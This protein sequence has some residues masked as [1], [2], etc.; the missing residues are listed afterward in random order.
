MNI[1]NPTAAEH[2][3]FPLELIA[4]SVAH[5]LRNPLAGIRAAAQLAREGAL[6]PGIQEALRDVISEVD[7][8]DSR[9]RTFLDFSRP[10]C[11]NVRPIQ[12]EEWL[13]GARP[14]IEMRVR[15]HGSRV[16]FCEKPG[17]PCL[18]ADPRLLD[19]AVL[20][21]VSN[22]LASLG[23]EP[24]NIEIRVEPVGG[25]VRISVADSGPGI[26]NSI[27]ERVFELLFTTRE[28]G[29]G[30]G[31]ALARRL[32]ELQGGRIELAVSAPGRTEFWIYLPTLARC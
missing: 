21:L 17:T 5:G 13:L 27:R 31:L 1:T 32:L 12:V 26:P 2:S 9:V 4:T 7:R 30:L 28:C 11:A 24:G 3:D 16:R 6:D 23:S 20:E 29:T 18:L 10:Y 8:A 15:S 22:S 14:A 19:E 25:T